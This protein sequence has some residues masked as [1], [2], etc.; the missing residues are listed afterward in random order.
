MS[1]YSSSKGNGESSHQHFEGM[2][3]HPSKYVIFEGLVMDFY[4]HHIY[5]WENPKPC[6]LLLD[7]YA[8]RQKQN[9]K[10]EINLGKK[11]VYIPN[12]ATDLAHDSY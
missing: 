4:L 10:I 5:L 7:R 9:K 1:I 11:L 8:S 3:S 6:I 12:S 2:T